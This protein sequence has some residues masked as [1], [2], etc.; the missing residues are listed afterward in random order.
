MNRLT[1][2]EYGCLL[3]LAA[4]CRSEDPTTQVGCALFNAETHRVISTAYNGLASGMNWP[5]EFNKDRNLKG[6]L[7]LHAENNLFN[8]E[9]IPS[10]KKIVYLTISPCFACS[11]II[12]SNNVE[13]VYYINEYARDT[14]KKFKQVFDFYGIKHRILTEKE[15]GNIF[16]WMI[17]VK[18]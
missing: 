1:K 3:A 2:I 12:A 15:K 9:N 13:A 5:E 6:E 17:H 14:E 10:C 16:N 18:V 7:V 4:S 11:K 8:V